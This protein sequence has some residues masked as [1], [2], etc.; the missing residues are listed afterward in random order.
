ME[1]INALDM[2]VAGVIGL[3]AMQTL[4]EALFRAQRSMRRTRR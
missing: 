2:L 4:I 3:C 1:V